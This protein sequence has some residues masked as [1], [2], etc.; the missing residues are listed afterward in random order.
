MKLGNSDLNIS[1]IILGTWAIG[2]SN[3]GKYDE[4][5]A[6]NAIESALDNGI[7]TIDTAPAYGDGHAESLIGKIIKNKRE[8]VII[9]TKCG[10]NIDDKYKKNLSPDF[11]EYELA[12]SLKRLQTD[13]I[14][15]YQCH[16]PDPNIPIEDTMKALLKHQDEGK[17]RYIGISNFSD[18]EI[19]ESLK[20]ATIT[21]LQSQYSLLER[22]IEENIKG[23]CIDNNIG[24]ITYGSIGGG[25]LTGKYKE[26]PKFGI[27]DAR[28]F[29]YKYFQKKYWDGVKAL[30]D[31]MDEMAE[32][33][34]IKP[35]NL[36]ISWLLSQ[37][38]V[39]ST[40]VGA[41]NR[42]QVL[43]NMKGTEFTLSEKDMDILNTL[44]KSVY[45]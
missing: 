35:S 40:I 24:I 26:L 38:G 21:T 22:S 25:M 7:N 5:D 18:K 4:N 10:L 44:S 34:G 23:I 27:T 20:Y 45:Q 14:D 42:K 16:W 37:E 43:E 33:K 30:V 9:A 41:R 6:I 17:I 13:Y 19:E 36:A 32:E 11:I 3:W 1:R 29:F 2:G 8:E 12:Q 15:L 31:K 39:A 28:S